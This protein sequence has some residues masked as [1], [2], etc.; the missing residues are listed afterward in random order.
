MIDVSAPPFQKHWTWVTQEMQDIKKK[1]TI[2]LR[3]FNTSENLA[4]DRDDMRRDLQF[5][6]EF[7]HFFRHWK[8]T[9]GTVA[10]QMYLSQAVKETSIVGIVLQRG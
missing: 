5:W 9:F 1:M 10:Y 6:K 3:N 8:S 7:C 2:V 4:N